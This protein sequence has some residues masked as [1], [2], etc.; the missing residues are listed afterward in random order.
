MT[1]VIVIENNR[2]YQTD[3][4]SEENGYVSQITGEWPVFHGSWLSFYEETGVYLL[5]P[6]DKTDMIIKREDLRKHI[7]KGSDE[8]EGNDNDIVY[9]PLVFT[10]LK[11]KENG[12]ECDIPVDFGILE[13]SSWLSGYK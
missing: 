1:K 5:G 4:D 6:R 8:E 11:H 9:G 12:V 2:M 13:Y 10:K 7:P 3:I